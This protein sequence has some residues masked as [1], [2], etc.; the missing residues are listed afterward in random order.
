MEPNRADTSGM[1]QTR[2]QRRYGRTRQR[3]IKAARAVF[4]ERG[5]SGIA[6]DQITERADVGRGS[7]YYHFGSIDKLV[8]AIVDSIIDELV[9]RMERECADKTELQDVLEALIVAHIRYFDDRWQDFVLYYQ[10]RA[11]LTL[12]MPFEGI[13]SPFLRYMKVIERL[14]GGAAGELAVDEQKLQRIACSLA[15]FISGYYSFARIA[16]VGDN[17]EAELLPIRASFVR[18]LVRFA[19][20]ESSANKK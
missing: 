11:E 18:S 8:Q 5:M 2:H 19:G 15:G 1:T 12:A 20:T 7:F 17:L 10:G 4:A 16:P 13:E 6:I 3:I 14:V 9:E